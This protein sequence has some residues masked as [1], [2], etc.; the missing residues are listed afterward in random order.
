M[1]LDHLDIPKHN[2]VLHLKY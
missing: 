2:A 1:S